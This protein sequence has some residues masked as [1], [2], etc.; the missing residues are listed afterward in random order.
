V[1]RAESETPTPNAR[2][3]EYKAK[4][5]AIQVVPEIA[6]MVTHVLFSVRMIFFSALWYVFIQIGFRI[7]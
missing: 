3:E 6:Y 7:H 1:R 5:S 2:R 4:A